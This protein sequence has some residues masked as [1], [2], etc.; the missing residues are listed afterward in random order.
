MIASNLESIPRRWVVRLALSGAACYLQIATAMGVA[1][2][3]TNETITEDGGAEITQ[4][5]IVTPL[6]SYHAGVING[7]LFRRPDD[8]DESKSGSGIFRDLYTST[9]G[10]SS[11]DKQEGYNRHGVMDSHIPGG[12][13]PFLRVGELVSDGSNSFFVFV[14]DTNEP[15]GGSGK[16]ISLDD[17]KVFVGGGN[18][19]ESLPQSEAG[20]GSSLGLPVYDMNPDG[21]ENTVLLDYS[22][23]SGSGQMDLFVFVP[24][25][26]FAGL[27]ADSL[28]YVYTEFG[29]YRGSAG[30]D[31]A[32]GP[33]QVSIPG[34]AITGVV[35]T[36]V[37]AESIPE[38]H[39][40]LLSLLG[41]ALLL[42]LR[43]RR[44]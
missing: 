42:G 26:A 19:P 38:P 32:A 33:E 15:G 1:V 41:A 12:F 27:A 9:G 35:D 17:F 21:E 11:A 28:V 39:S 7:G 8:L 2:N 18:D 14:I 3:L 25:S 4:S 6:G 30:F 23:Y 29:G 22:L 44:H 13:D 16:Y 5:I 43:C 20:M 10:S 36:G 34:K 37:P 40:C 24:Q 31:A